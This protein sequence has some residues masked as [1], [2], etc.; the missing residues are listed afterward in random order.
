LKINVGRIKIKKERINPVI[1]IG[2]P[3]CVRPPNNN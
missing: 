3:N 1:T 2:G